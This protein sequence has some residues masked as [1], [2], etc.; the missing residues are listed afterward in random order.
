MIRSEVN[1]TALFCAFCQSFTSILLLQDFIGQN[2]E[3]EEQQENVVPEL[4]QR[5]IILVK[6]ICAVLFHFKFETEISSS[7]QMMKYSAMHSDYF[8]NPLTSYFMGL[9]N[10]VMIM[11]VEV[12]NLWNLSNITEGTYSLMFDFIALGIIAEFDDYFVEIYKDS[13]LDPL[14]NGDVTLTFDRTKMPKRHLPNLRETKL[15]KWMGKIKENLKLFD[16]HC[17]E[18][19]TRNKPEIA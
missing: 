7:I 9:I 11:L 16:T 5:T 19:N 4:E 13:A 3:E 14:I 8:Y 6:F 1:L 10:M 2:L 15:E 18:M 12:I 17:N